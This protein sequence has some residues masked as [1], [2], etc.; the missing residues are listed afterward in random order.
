MVLPGT[1][2]IHRHAGIGKTANIIKPQRRCTI[3]DTPGGV[4]SGSQIR[5]SIHLFADFQQLAVVIK[6]L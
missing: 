2:G 4:G 6:R 3:A 1:D 5:Y